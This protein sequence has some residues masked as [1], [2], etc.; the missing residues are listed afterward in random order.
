MWHNEGVWLNVCTRLMHP[1]VKTLAQSEECRE[2]IEALLK[3]HKEK[4]FGKYFGHCNQLRRELDKC[5]QRDYT[6]RRQNNWE[7]SLK[8]K[9]RAR[10]LD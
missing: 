8:R 6:K 4:S 7:D 1:P 5:L 9:E 2:V 3:C 10:S